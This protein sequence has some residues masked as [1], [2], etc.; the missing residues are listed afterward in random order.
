MLEVKVFVTLDS[1]LL[2]TSI[3]LLYTVENLIEASEALS[4]RSYS[5]FL[6]H[7]HLLKIL[8]LICKNH[9]KVEKRKKLDDNLTSR[10]N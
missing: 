5:I 9:K 1:L 8:H 7:L 4:L 2:F 10:T 6:L 3:I